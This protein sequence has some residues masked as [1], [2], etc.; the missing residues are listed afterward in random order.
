MVAES[1]RGRLVEVGTGHYIHHDDP[2]LVITEV[3]RM[4]GLVTPDSGDPAAAGAGDR[5]HR[6]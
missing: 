6:P 2:D 4:I 1:E 3:R 5:S